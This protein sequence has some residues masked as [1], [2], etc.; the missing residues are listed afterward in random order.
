MPREDTNAIKTKKQ[1]R[2]AVANQAPSLHGTMSLT[3]YWQHHRQKLSA[4][5]EEQKV[6]LEGVNIAAEIKKIFT[7]EKEA[8]LKDF[9]EL[10]HTQTTIT[11]TQHHKPINLTYLK[12]HLIAMRLAILGE[13]FDDL[14]ALSW[15]GPSKKSVGPYLEKLTTYFSDSS[16]P[17]CL[18]EQT[19]RFCQL[20]Y[21]HTNAFANGLVK[22]QHAIVNQ[23]MQSKIKDAK[24]NA[25][26]LQSRINVFLNDQKK[27]SKKKQGKLEEQELPS[28]NQEQPNFSDIVTQNLLQDSPWLATFEQAFCQKII[29]FIQSNTYPSQADSNARASQKINDSSWFGHWFSAWY[30][31]SAN[32]EPPVSQNQ[33]AEENVSDLVNSIMNQKTL[34][35]KLAQ[36]YHIQKRLIEIRAQEIFISEFEFV[37]SSQDTLAQPDVLTK[38]AVNDEFVIYQ[39]CEYYIQ[40]ISMITAFYE[41]CQHLVTQYTDLD[42]FTKAYHTLIEKT[43]ASIG[44]LVKNSCTSDNT[45]YGAL[46]EFYHKVPMPNDYIK[47]WYHAHE[48]LFRNSKSIQQLFKAPELA[49]PA[50]RQHP[51]VQQASTQQPDGEEE[52]SIDFLSRQFRSFFS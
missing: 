34:E 40:L 30:V 23:F 37:D 21:D 31:T 36:Y 12:Y 15:S 49:Q 29:Q 28:D 48:D 14:P 11:R 41:N 39:Q 33:S 38:L 5:F 50:P 24:T 1:E 19:T 35:N 45:V 2:V 9:I 52:S 7:T 42:S 17:E 46:M 22:S 47:E 3:Q 10:I 51:S 4:L 27:N 43:Y 20:Y 44:G 26:I 13:T 8:D 6:H 18:E 25:E 16:L 32:K